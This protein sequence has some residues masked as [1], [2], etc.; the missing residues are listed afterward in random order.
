MSNGALAFRVCFA[1]GLFGLLTLAGLPAA[2]AVNRC[3]GPNGGVVF[4]DAPCAG[5][6]EEITIRPSRGKVKEPDPLQASPSVEGTPSASGSGNGMTTAQRINAQVAESQRQRRLAE[7]KE[8]L[9][10]R[11]VKEI[12]NLHQTCKREFDR[13]QKLRE[14]APEDRGIA[15][16]Q[17]LVAGK[18]NSKQSQQVRKLEALREECGTL[19]GDC[20]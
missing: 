20:E 8:R 6:G 15:I 12:R 16:A 2:Q 19:Y 5:R 11:Q 10:P 9:I 17:S 13:L 4:Q 1:F 14:Q 18:C 7:L 3:E